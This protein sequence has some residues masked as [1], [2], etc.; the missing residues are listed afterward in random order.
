[1][2]KLRQNLT[3]FGRKAKAGFSLI[4][5]SESIRYCVLQLLILSF[6]TTLIVEAF[7]RFSLLKAFGFLFTHPILFLLNM[8]ITAIP[9]S[10]ALLFRR[11][12]YLL[13]IISLL[14]IT[15]GIIDFFI[16]HNRVTPFN[17]NDFK[18][19]SDGWNVLFHYYTTIQ[20]IGLLLLIAFG[21]FLLIFGFI[22]FPKSKVAVDY[23]IRLPLFVI[24]VAVSLSLVFI[25][26]SSGTLAKSFP[27][28]ADAYHDYGFSYCFSCSVFDNGIEKPSNYSSEVVDEVIDAVSDPTEAPTQTDAGSATTVE[29]AD[30][31]VIF[32]Q[33]ESFFDPKRI[34]GLEFETDPIPTFTYLRDNYTSGLLTVPSI[35]AGTANTEFEI[36]T[37]MNMHDFGTGE[38]PYKTILQSKTCES[39]AYNLRNLGLTAHAIHDNIATFYSRNVVYSNLGFEDFDTLE[40]MQDV[41]YN[42]LNWAKD[43]VLYKE[44]MSAL[45]STSGKDFVFTVSVQGHGSYPDEDILDNSID[46]VDVNDAYSD[47]TIYGLKYYISQINEMDSFVNELIGTLSD[48]DEPVVLVLY[49]D[50][51][52]GFDFQ[53]EDLNRGTT[54]QTEYVMWSNFDMEAEHRDLTSYQ[55]SAYV[56][57]RLGLHEGLIT[58]LQ[59]KYLTDEDAD[60]DEYLNNLQVL[61]Y[62]M[63]YG[64]MYCFGGVSPYEPT[65]LVYG[66]YRPA[67][68]GVSVI[69][70][71]DSCYLTVGGSGFTSY[72]KIYVN[73]VAVDKT[74]YVSENQLFAAD[75]EL[76]AGDI[77]TIC[78]VASRDLVLASSDEYEYT[79]DCIVNPVTD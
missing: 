19:L 37:G 55:L 49:G 73:G 64:D 38:Y 50:H 69:K 46:L 42:Q 32:I 54:L 7:S 47:D 67:I 12:P 24:I 75:L 10:I 48:Y 16:L 27:N 62:D 41:E 45:K 59:Q 3:A 51:L 43:K 39:L 15:G 29:Q 70:S 52:P 76:T 79:E 28:I 74:I 30:V 22:K 1:M 63:L 35:S 40:M 61:S 5:G 44:I 25:G 72:S 71:G 20:A 34:N 9:I 13:F 57:E 33:L 8:A 77:I 58:K 68:S 6:A 18:M 14:W 78:T 31:N 56:Q 2:S 23:R 53:D 21:I 4:F 36:L 17:A 66:F 11:K 60:E 65:D 26:R